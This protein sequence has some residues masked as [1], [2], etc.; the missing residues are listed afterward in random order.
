MARQ[1]RATLVD[2]SA[3]TRKMIMRYL[4]DSGLAEFTFTDRDPR[5]DWSLR[6]AAGSAARLWDALKRRRAR[7]EICFT[8]HKG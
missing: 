3:M 2:D 1:I 6:R 7:A 5:G 4:H 8:I